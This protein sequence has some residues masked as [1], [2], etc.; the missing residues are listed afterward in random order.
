MNFFKKISIVFVF[1]L[2][3]LVG[4]KSNIQAASNEPCEQYLKEL[5]NTRSFKKLAAWFTEK[6]IVKFGGTAL[7]LT[8]CKKLGNAELFGLGMGLDGDTKVATTIVLMI[9]TGLLATLWPTISETYFMRKGQSSIALK[10][11]NRYVSSL[12]STQKVQFEQI[13]K[14]MQNEFVV[15]TLIDAVVLPLIFYFC[16]F[17][18]DTD[19]YN[20]T[21]ALVYGLI[22]AIGAADIRHNI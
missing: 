21:F 18:S 8:F 3:L 2:G 15:T 14:S 7:L 13:K 9:L 1:G 11:L 6:E 22:S 17:K 10:N 12:D 20:K 16:F 19:D 5:V 4:V